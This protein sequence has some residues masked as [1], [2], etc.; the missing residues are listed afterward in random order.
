MLSYIM[1]DTSS[2]SRSFSWFNL[3]FALLI[4]LVSLYCFYISLLGFEVADFVASNSTFSPFF[5]SV[6]GSS[7]YDG[8]TIAFS[9]VNL[10]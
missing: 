4:S 9:T 5:I 6:D 10:F 8:Y 2:T 1:F 3:I 7:R